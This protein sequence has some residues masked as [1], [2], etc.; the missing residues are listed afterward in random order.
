MKLC[1]NFILATT[2]LV[3]STAQAFSGAATIPY[4]IEMISQNIKRYHQLKSMV[5]ET[6][7]NREYLRLINQGIDNAQGIMDALPIENK[8]SKNLGQTQNEI[9]KIYGTIPKGKGEAIFKRHDQSVA[10]SLKLIDNSK[11]YAKKQEQNSKRI[12]SQAQKASPKGAQRMTAVT[13]SQILHALSQLIRI[14]GQ[15]LKL[16]SE[17]LAEKNKHS[18][19]SARH[20]NRINQELAASFKGYRGKFGVSKF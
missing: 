5:K 12:F 10:E 11:T 7:E 15:I 14:N 18:K 20:F 16:Q 2:L 4:L 13:N 17:T 1:L 9:N 19:D 6:K 8:N 3:P